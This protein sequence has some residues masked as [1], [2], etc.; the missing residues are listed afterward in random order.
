MT[1]APAYNEKELLLRTAEGDEQ[2]FGLLFQAYANKLGHYVHRFTRSFILTQEIVQ[3]VFLKIWLN[4]A[5]LREMDN[6]SAYLF[7]AARNHTFNALKQLARE[8]DKQKQWQLTLKEELNVNAEN[9]GYTET[10]AMINKAIAA[11]PPQQKKVFLLSREKGLTQEE[12]AQELQLSVT[13]VKKHMVLAL[14]S[15]RE[16]L[17]VKTNMLL[18]VLFAEFF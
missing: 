8:Y 10:A 13:T 17:G 3:D 12:I 11:L 14:K 4:R 18:L 2:A 15:L 16:Q 5:A 9:T 6:F 7:V 1:D